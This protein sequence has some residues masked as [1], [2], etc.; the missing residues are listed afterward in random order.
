VFFRKKYLQVG[1]AH[2]DNLLTIIDKAKS[3]CRCTGNLEPVGYVCSNCEASL[4]DMEDS[5]LT[6]EDVN[7]FGDS[8]KRCKHCGVT[9]FPEAVYECD[10]CDDPIPLAF[11]EVV[12]KVKKDGVGPK[13]II[14]VDS[15][16]P[17][18]EFSMDNKQGIVES[19]KDGNAVI[20]ND[21]FVLIEELE[22]PTTMQWNFEKSHPAPENSE[23]SAFLRLQEGDPGYEASA[24][25][26]SK[27][28]PI[29][30]RR[31]R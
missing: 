31:F 22:E 3:R 18:S 11:N 10:T 30:R 13:T 19:D 8:K 16:I 17:L 2:Y 28:K 21:E 26:Y 7:R 1:S 15:I 12:A 6:L 20:E 14:Q 25:G 9:A 27:R 4:L 5:D 23:V 24:R 29:K